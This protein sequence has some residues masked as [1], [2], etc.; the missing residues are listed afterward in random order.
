MTQLSDNEYLFTSE[1]VTEGHPDKVADRQRAEQLVARVG[2]LSGAEQ[3]RGVRVLVA[4]RSAIAFAGGFLAVGA[5]ADEP[6]GQGED[7]ERGERE[8]VLALER[9][10]H[11]A[12]RRCL[13][14]AKSMITGIPSSP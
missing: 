10:D 2:N 7:G 13:R 14:S 1:S 9:R 4:G 5:R 8:E 11:A 3:Y 6:G 12:R